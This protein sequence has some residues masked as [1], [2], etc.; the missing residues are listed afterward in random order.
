MLIH[1]CSYVHMCALPHRYDEDSGDLVLLGAKYR[2]REDNRRWCLEALHLMLHEA[3]RLQGS[4]GAQ[5]AAAQTEFLLERP[6]V[7]SLLHGRA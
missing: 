5:G 1:A 7:A 2:T 3:H 4:L 6:G